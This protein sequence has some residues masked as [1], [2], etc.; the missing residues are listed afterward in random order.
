MNTSLVALLPLIFQGSPDWLLAHG[1]FEAE[2]DTAPTPAHIALQNGLIRR[3][4][5][6][7]PNAACVTFRNDMT[8]AAILRSIRPEAMVRIDGEDFE[9][10]GL[11]GQPDHAYLRPEWIEKLEADPRAFQ[12]THLEVGVPLERF[13]WKRVRY[14][15]NT[16]WPPAGSP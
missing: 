15:A 7:S 13:A 9:V 3:E 2:M 10:G 5:V 6:L 12:F 4:W 1:K 8:G 11:R 14:A 16:T